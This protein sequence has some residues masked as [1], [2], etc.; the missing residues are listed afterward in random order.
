MFWI[1]GAVLFGVLYFGYRWH[2]NKDLP[3]GPR[4]VPI[5]GYLPW[6][7]PKR[8]YET[9]TRLSGKYGPTYSIQMGK[10]FAVV[11]SDP[12]TVRAALARNELA[13]RTN[14]EVVNEIMQEHGMTSNIKTIT[15]TSAVDNV[16]SDFERRSY[17]H[18]RNALERTTEIHLQLAQ[19]DWRVQGR[20]KEKRFTKTY[21]RSRDC[22]TFGASHQLH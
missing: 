8:P 15:C 21:H 3:P 7:D 6:L 13:D 9:L 19:I 20:G 2:S 10:H 14:F 17:I 12:A 22:D 11:M 1:V 18:T 5:L 16:I 4:G